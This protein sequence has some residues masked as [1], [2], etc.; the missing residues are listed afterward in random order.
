MTENTHQSYAMPNVGCMIGTAFQKL[1]SRLDTSLKQAGLD[2]TPSE[3]MLMRAVA[4]RPGMQQCEI[5]EMIGKDKASICRGVA[6]M[7]KKGYFR[8]ESVSHKCL[9]VYL[10]EKGEELLPRIMEVAR[11]R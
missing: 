3:Y 5:G 7:V 4:K 1:A 8:T 6:A 9:R 10:S 2:L 11:A